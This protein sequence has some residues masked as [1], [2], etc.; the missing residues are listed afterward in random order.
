MK[1]Q[2]SG[3]FLATAVV[4]VAGTAQAL[5]QQRQHLDHGTV[6]QPM[7]GSVGFV[8]YDQFG[9]HNISTG[10]TVNVECPLPIDV[11][12]FPTVSEQIDFVQVVAY[13]RSTTANVNC[14]LRSVDIKGNV[15]TYLPASTSNGGPGSGEQ[16]LSFTPPANTPLAGFWSLVCSIPAVQ[17]G[18]FSHVS[19]ILTVSHY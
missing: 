8:D 9:V 3:I 10:A 14:A 13:D 1:R 18:A 11:Q 6:C 19:T 12:V 2:I 16:Y 7:A 4:L 17:S 5:T 15:L